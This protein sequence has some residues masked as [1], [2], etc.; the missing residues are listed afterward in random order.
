MHFHAPTVRRRLP[1]RSGTT[2][3]DVLSGALSL[4]LFEVMMNRSYVDVDCWV[5]AA[6]VTGCVFWME[7][8]EGRLLPRC[9]ACGQLGVRPG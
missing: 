7:M 2:I 3:F 5:E 9:G 8:R 4:T 6:F 1:R